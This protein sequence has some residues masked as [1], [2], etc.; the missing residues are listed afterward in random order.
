MEGPIDLAADPAIDGLELLL[1]GGQV[2]EV[3][4]FDRILELGESGR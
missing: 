3:D 1:K 2:V 4:L